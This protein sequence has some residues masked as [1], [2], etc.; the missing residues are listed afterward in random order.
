MIVTICVWKQ[1][2]K[3]AWLFVVS[4]KHETWSRLELP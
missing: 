1:T 3:A 2:F 4:L